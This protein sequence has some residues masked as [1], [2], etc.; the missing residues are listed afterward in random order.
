MP[1][2]LAAAIM[3]NK[4]GAP[5]SYDLMT[6]GPEHL[7]TALEEGIV[8]KVDWKS[9]LPKEVARDVLIS[10]PPYEDVGLSCYTSQQG[11]IYNTKKVS[12]KEV[13]KTMKELADVK[14]KGKVG[15]F[16]YTASWAVRAHLLGK[17]NVYSSLRAILKN[18][19]IQGRYTDLYSR[20]LLEEI[21]IA[22]VGNSYYMEAQKKGMPTGW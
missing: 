16:D 2:D 18:G 12:P 4:V 11:L 8:E 3:E 5:P 17:D 13:P 21:W 9:L 15:V 19:A 22:G 20:F 7:M 6:F 14:W 10:L 1:K